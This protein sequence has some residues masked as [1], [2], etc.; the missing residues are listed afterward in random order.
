MLK[1]ALVKKTLR[2]T[3]VCTGA[4]L[5]LVL[6]LLCYKVYTQVNSVHWGA[7]RFPPQSPLKP[8]PKRIPVV[9]MG[10]VPQTL[11]WDDCKDTPAPSNIPMKPLVLVRDFEMNMWN[12]CLL[13]N[14]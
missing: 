3:D 5:C 8:V 14:L 7:I 11:R 9:Q 2:T 13:E 4:D 6:C 10:F 12:M 1:D